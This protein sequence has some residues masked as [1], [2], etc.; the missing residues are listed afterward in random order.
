MTSPWPHKPYTFRALAK[1]FGPM[2]LR[3]DVCGRYARFHMG[4]LAEVDY[5]AKTFSCSRRGAEAYLALVEPIKETGMAAYRLDEL[6]NPQRHQA[7]ADRLCGRR[8]APYRSRRRRAARPE[9]RWPT[10]A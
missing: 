7:A 1:T 2:W 6:D 10:L 9:G 4:E 8:R 3:R 5:R